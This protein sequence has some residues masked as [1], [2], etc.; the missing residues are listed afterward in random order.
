MSI[1]IVGN[2]TKVRDFAHICKPMQAAQGQICAKAE[3]KPAR[4]SQEA[5]K[6][7]MEVNKNAASSNVES[8]GSH[9]LP[10]AVE[11]ALYW[12]ESTRKPMDPGNNQSCAEWGR[13]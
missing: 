12:T 8:F 2:E 4:R 5:R 7:G 3:K 1:L 10:N 11:I 9:I 13:H 6:A